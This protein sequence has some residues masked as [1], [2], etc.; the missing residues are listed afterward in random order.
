MQIID[1]IL[2]KDKIAAL[3]NQVKAL[4][5]NNIPITAAQFIYPTWL[6]QSDTERYATIDEV[7]SIITY[8]A[9]TAATI[10]MY[11]YDVVDDEN[12]KN[13]KR[14]DPKTIQ[15]KYFRLKSLEDLPE[16][17]IVSRILAQFSYEK[18]VQMY[19]VLLAVGEVIFWKE[20][21]EFGP[22]KGLCT[23]HMLDSSRVTVVVS[24]TLPKRIVRYDYVDGTNSFSFMPEEI[25]HIKY[26]DPRYNMGWRGLSPLA[27]LRRRLTRVNS[28]MDAS[29]AQVQNGGVPGIVFEK[30]ADFE[31][32]EKNGLRKDSF[33]RYLRNSENKGAPYF[34]SGEMGYLPIGSTLADMDLLELTKEDFSKICM[35][36]HFPEHLISL[37]GATDN[38][39]KWA[40][41][42]LY[43]TSILPN[44]YRLRDAINYQVLP[45]VQGSE[46]K[47][48]DCDISEVSAL[49]DDMQQ[50]ATALNT[51]WWITPNEKREIQ[52]FGVSDMEIMDKFVVPSG[53]MLLDELTGL[54]PVND[55]GNL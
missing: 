23:F 18:K 11:G 15:A 16:T 19:T 54:P 26:F 24:E 50:Q 9:E 42:R 5:R 13:Y 45:F 7:Y 49:Q 36:Y 28:A 47:Y 3:E 30:G 41:K 21:I 51:M 43:T 2:G 33:G 10:P 52:N 12:F 25:M 40:E 34:A 38:N 8:M 17:D 22:D 31:A 46:K 27:V 39:M 6:T 35:A 48:V 55:T 29:V 44:I 1:R 37:S 53:M 20:V 14:K 32:V 4:Q